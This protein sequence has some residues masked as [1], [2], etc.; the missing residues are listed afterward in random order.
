MIPVVQN[1]LGADGEAARPLNRPGGACQYARA[2]IRRYFVSLLV[3]FL[4]AC[5]T[6]VATQTLPELTYGHLST[7]TFNVADVHVAAKYLPPMKAPNVDHLFATPPGKALRRWAADRLK[8]GAG[9]APRGSSSSTP[10]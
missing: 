2:M 7:F 6:P 10:R 5:E 3:V 9:G 8:A 4:A 1:S